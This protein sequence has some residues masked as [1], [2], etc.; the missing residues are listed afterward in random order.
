MSYLY[1]NSLFFHNKMFRISFQLI[2]IGLILIQS[3]F[4]QK[5]TKLIQ[6]EEDRPLTWEDFKG[7]PSVTTSYYAMTYGMLEP[8]FA[9]I[10]G[11][12]YKFTLAVSFDTKRS[13]VKKGKGTEELLL[14]EQNHFNIFE[15]YARIFMKRL[16]DEDVFEGKNFS[17]EL[18]KIFQKTFK[19][20]TNIQDKYDKETNHSINKTKQ[21]EWNE[22]LS[23]MLL[24]Y[25][26]YA[27]REV[28]FE[29]Q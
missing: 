24:E 17:K 15:I 9:P 7:R 5:K 11:G 20:L 1:S 28:I 6:W 22:K 19:E 4:G 2:I 16:K 8:A 25:Q 12:K 10:D 14:H 26:D 13:W 21:K 23:N 29:V 27:Y 3:S 18:N